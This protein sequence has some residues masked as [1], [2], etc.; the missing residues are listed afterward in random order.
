MHDRDDRDLP[1]PTAHDLTLRDGRRLEVWEYGDPGG[2]PAVFFHGLIGSHHQASYI[3]AQARRRGLR[4]IAPN[5]PGVGRSAFATR[6]TA[7]D[8]VPDVE[9]LAGALGLGAFSV[10]G[11]SG[12]TP[13]ALATFYRLGPRVRTVTVISGMGPMRLPGALTGM[14][15][16]RRLFLEVG[17]RHPGLAERAFEK[18][19]D[20]FRADPER[21]LGRLV[22]SWPAPD[23]RVFQRRDIFDFF[24]RDLHQVFTDGCDRAA[25]GLA[26]ELAV[27]R[28]YGFSLADLPA[29]RRVTL[30]Q[31]LSD[32][33]VPP[34]MAWAM[35]R[36]L[37][38]CEAH[39]VPGGHFM[40][41][42][43]ADQ[44]VTRLRQL[45]DDPP[46][47]PDRPAEP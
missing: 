47:N 28:N 7:L 12:G 26:Q 18:G 20:R 41:V 39:L 13:Y 25:E 16:R 2:H 24:L 37:P 32:T 21:F 14:D 33:I 45:L 46:A 35:A 19:A 38:N 1:A 34:S 8:A 15:R 40:A 5:R 30:W 9:D 23:R 43:V 29:D 4:I 3:T 27:Y 31:G 36:R 17:A 44:I 22:A 10:I 6:R 42:D 11:I